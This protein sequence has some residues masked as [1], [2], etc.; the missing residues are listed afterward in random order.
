MLLVTRNWEIGER[1]TVRKVTNPGLPC[2]WPLKQ[3][4]S[5]SSSSINS[6]NSSSSVNSFEVVNDQ[7]KLMFFI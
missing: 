5:S 2:Q 4:N 1:E 3:S 6:I 7:M